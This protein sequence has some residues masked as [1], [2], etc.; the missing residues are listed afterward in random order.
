MTNGDRSAKR[1]FKSPRATLPINFGQ[2]HEHPPYRRINVVG[3]PGS[4]FTTLGCALGDSENLPEHYETVAPH[5]V[6][7]VFECF[8]MRNSHPARL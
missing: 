6:R 8:R 7:K 5:Y 1:S 4:G 3:V 2:I